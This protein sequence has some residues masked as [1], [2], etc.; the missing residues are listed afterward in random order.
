MLNPTAFKSHTCDKHELLTFQINQIT[1]L[2]D[3]ELLLTSPNPTKIL[4][5]QT[6]DPRMSL[7]QSAS[8]HL[9]TATFC[10]KLAQR[11]KKDTKMISA[12]IA[13]GNHQLFVLQCLQSRKEQTTVF[14]W[15]ILIPWKWSTSYLNFFFSSRC[16]ICPYLQ[17]NIHSTHKKRLELGKPRN[18]QTICFWSF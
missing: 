1:N 10:A 7:L 18:W 12:L 9:L 8:L 15:C 11:P 5:H 4:K 14:L 6:F 17:E 13:D 16:H 3:S 2:P